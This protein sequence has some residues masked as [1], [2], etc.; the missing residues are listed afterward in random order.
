MRSCETRAREARLAEAMGG[1][2]KERGVGA[3]SAADRPPWL[4]DYK[5]THHWDHDGN[6]HD[7]GAHLSQEQLSSL[8]DAWSIM[9]PERA[10]TAAAEANFVRWDL[11]CAR[12]RLF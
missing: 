3:L 5:S 7:V 6:G 8:Q 11:Q 12:F 10:L 1:A 2:D 4:N 9:G